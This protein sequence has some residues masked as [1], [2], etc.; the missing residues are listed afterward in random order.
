MIA[1]AFSILTTI[2]GWLIIGLLLC[3]LLL[4]IVMMVAHPLDG[5]EASHDPGSADRHTDNSC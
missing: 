3:V 2:A 4:T 5:E 1:T